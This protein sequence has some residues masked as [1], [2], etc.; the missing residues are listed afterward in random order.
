ME[1]AA[2][3]TFGAVATD[4]LEKLKDEGKSESTIEKNKWLL[5]DLA[6]PLTKRPVTKI[7]PMTELDVKTLVWTRGNL[8]LEVFE[9]NCA[10]PGVG[11]CG[12][13]SC[14]RCR[15]SLNKKTGSW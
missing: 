5:E 14:T 15:T 3:N 2:K 1:T 6:S 11:T 8:P 10:V 12:Y 9:K 13:R 7:T 4:Y